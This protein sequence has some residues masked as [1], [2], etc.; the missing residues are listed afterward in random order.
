MLLCSIC[1]IFIAFI[2]ALVISYTMNV[3][4]YS[5]TLNYYVIIANTLVKRVILMRVCQHWRSLPTLSA[6]VCKH[7][8]VLYT[9]IESI[10][11]TLTA[12]IYNNFL[13]YLFL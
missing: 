7:S 2:S 8:P 13:L 9:H 1:L 3:E 4:C 6:A 5:N 10:L 11:L 12:Q